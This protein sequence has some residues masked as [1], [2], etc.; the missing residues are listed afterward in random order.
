MALTR[1]EDNFGVLK[2]GQIPQQ[3][4]QEEAIAADRNYILKFREV[5]VVGSHTAAGATLQSN[6][7]LV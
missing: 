2:A 4:D 6:L 5:L 7:C 3:I 1:A